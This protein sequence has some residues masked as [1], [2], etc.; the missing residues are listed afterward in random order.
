MKNRYERAELLRKA[1]EA[2]GYTQM[3]IAD[4]LN[5]SNKTISKWETGESYPTDYNTLQKYARI[6][7]LDINEIVDGSTLEDKYKINIGNIVIDLR[8]IFKIVVTILFTIFIMLLMFYIL[9]SCFEKG[10]IRIYDLKIDSDY[11]SLS[12]HTLF[13]SDKVNILDFAQVEG[14]NNINEVILYYK[15]DNNIVEIFRGSNN[16]Y[17]IK[18]KKSS[19]EYH[20]NNIEKKDVY[21]DIVNKD[22]T[23]ETYKVYF[24]EE[25]VND[26]ITIINNDLINYSN[27]VKCTK[28]ENIGFKNKDGVCIKEDNAN[29]IIFNGRSRMFTYDIYNYD[30][31]II[32]EKKLKT[33]YY[34]ILTIDTNGVIN[35]KNLRLIEAFKDNNE[36]IKEIYYYEKVL[37]S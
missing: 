30:E 26:K 10:K 37:F 11:L 7:D 17:K 2:K 9:Y 28:L 25:Y 14:S 5:Y 29:R 27:S 34:M 22:G 8:I 4:L 31:N 36:Y 35:V 20:L 21:L 15:E 23:K 16:G 6:L 13:I 33:K 12:N 19:N 18:D 24:I 32:I 3:E 1:R